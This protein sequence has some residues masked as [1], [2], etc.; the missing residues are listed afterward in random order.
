MQKLN[1]SLANPL[2]ILGKNLR[3]LEYRA[4]SSGIKFNKDKSWVLCLGQSNV[5]HRLGDEWLRAAQQNGICVHWRQQF[6]MSSTVK[7]VTHILGC[8]KHPIQSVQRGNSPITFS[9]A[10]Q[11]PCAYTGSVT[12]KGCTLRSSNV[13]GAGGNKAG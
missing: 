9:T 5:R 13:S 12:Q 2:M 1:L 6:T 4:L 11:I 8:I 3:R 7:M 10:V